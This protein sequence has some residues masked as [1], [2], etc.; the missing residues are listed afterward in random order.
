MTI[1]MESEE[2]EAL[3]QEVIKLRIKCAGSLANNLCPDH[4]DKQRGKPCL[5]CEIESQQ[6]RIAALEREVASLRNI[7]G[8]NLC[9]FD[10]GAAVHEAKALPEPQ[11]L[12]SCRRFRQQIADERGEAVGCMTIAQLEY[13][14]ANLEESLWWALEKLGIGIKDVQP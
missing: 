6:K 7:A 3:L 5:A 14:I 12:E 8:D 13:R 10:M 4:R 11:F 1:E 2:H 9:R